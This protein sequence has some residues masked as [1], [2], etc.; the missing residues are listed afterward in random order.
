MHNSTEYVASKNICFF[1]RP[2]LVQGVE[3]EPDANSNFLPAVVIYW[4]PQ[5]SIQTFKEVGKNWD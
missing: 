5:D 2:R 3:S 1:V 4:P